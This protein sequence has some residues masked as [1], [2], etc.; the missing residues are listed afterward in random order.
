MGRCLTQ[1]SKFLVLNKKAAWDSGLSVNLAVSDDGLKIRQVL[2]YVSQKE[3]EIEVLAGTFAVTDF[4]VAECSQ[5]YILDA[6]SRAIWVYDTK[7]KTIEKIACIGALF[8]KPTSITYAA[9]TLYVADAEAEERIYALAEL[10]WQIKFTVGASPGNDLF[11]LVTPFAPIDL[12]VDAERNLFALDDNNRA[13][14]RFDQAGQITDVFGQTELQHQ[15]PKSL[16]LSRDG[17][18]YVL[19]ADNQKILRFPTDGTGLKAG[20]TYV[21]FKSPTVR[22]FLPDEFLPSGFA[23]DESGILYVGDNGPRPLVGQEDDRFIHKFGPA[24]KYAGVV[25]DFRG[26]VDQMV[27]DPDNSIFV[28][29]ADMKNKITALRRELKFAQAEGAALVAGLY[30]SHGFDS[31]DAGTIWHK[32]SADTNTPASTQIWIS[33]LAADGKG[34]KIGA[35]TKEQDLDSFLAETAGLDEAIDNERIEKQKRLADLDKLEWSRA[36]TNAND[37]LLAAAGRYLWARIELI[38]SAKE[39]P[40]V[41]SLQV[42]FPR[43]SY[44]RYLP[45]VYQEDETGRDFLERFLS[46]FETF[47][48]G[49]ELQVNHIAR[50][51]DPDS[52]VAQGEFLR[53][54]ATWLAISADNIWDDARLRAL[55][56]RA[57]QIYKYRGTRAAIEEMI[58]IF[59]GERP[60]IVEHYQTS[61]AGWARQRVSEDIA[62]LKAL[63]ERLY[64]KDPF[65]FCVLL[66][67]FPVKTEEQRKA[68]RRI[69]DSEKPAHTCAGLLVLQPWVQLDTHT[70]LEINTFLSEPS[71]RLDFGSSMPRD[72]VLNDFEETGQLEIRSR[73]NSDIKLT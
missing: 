52:S 47:F 61:C 69:L 23:I 44:L 50:Y 6:A 2:E 72:T 31:A 37:A 17:L 8:K 54:L 18:L 46:L 11:P 64:G 32:F 4:A 12:A 56:K 57:A 7:Q 5:L 39:S 30:I 28:F 16:A 45:A 73:L 21:D 53:W 40:S 51:F 60:L 36:V 14:V 41:Q 63:Y 55:I 49:I 26:A 67:P 68:V 58:E 38:G 71:A 29:R 9:G 35:D 42:H 34:F 48:D 22:R 19:D 3:D 66:K 15:Q 13:I 65:C 27:V 24:G 1:E 62:A 33:F 10:N 70:Y 43:L 20:V 25:E 59:L